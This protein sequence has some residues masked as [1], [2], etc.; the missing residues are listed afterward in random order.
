MQVAENSA[1]KICDIYCHATIAV[2]IIL[3][4]L[5]NYQGKQ[6]DAQAHIQTPLAHHHTNAHTHTM[7]IENADG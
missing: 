1:N 7:K 5:D 6:V 2:T 4:T 3:H